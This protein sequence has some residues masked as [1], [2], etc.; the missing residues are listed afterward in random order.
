MCQTS[1][2]HLQLDACNFAKNNNF[3]SMC[4]PFVLP[5][6]ALHMA[7]IGQHAEAVRTLLLL[8]LQDS[9]DGSGATARQ[10]AKKQNVLRM[11][12]RDTPETH[13]GPSWNQTHV[14]PLSLWRFDTSETEA[15]MRQFCGIFFK[16]EQMVWDQVVSQHAPLSDSIMTFYY[17]HAVPWKVE[18]RDKNIYLE[19]CYEFFCHMAV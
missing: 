14:F 10:L 2:S 1:C 16:Y 11:F 7:C 13:T 6:W 15:I 17:A 3:Y 4:S 19:V 5:L 9:E 12:E 18:I 8:G